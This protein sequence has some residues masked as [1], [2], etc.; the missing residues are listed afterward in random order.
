MVRRPSVVRC[1]RRR[2]H[3]QCSKIF[4]SG[5]ALPIKAKFYVEPPWVG[6]NDILFAA[7]GS[8]DQD[9]CHAYIW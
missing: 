5:T 6:G 9:G 3:S 7:S 2:R 8:H 1:H 4:F